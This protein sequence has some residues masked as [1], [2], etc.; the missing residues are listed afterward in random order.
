[1]KKS[2]FAVAFLCLFFND[3]SA[4]FL[5]V[6]FKGGVNFSNFGDGTIEGVAFKNISSYHF[7][8]ITELKLLEN[9]AIQP[10]LLY[11]SQG[12][13]LKGLGEEFTNELGY[14]TLPILIKFYVVSNKLSIEAGPQAAVLIS[15]KNV[16]NFEDAKTF[17]LGFASGLSYKITKNIFVSGRYIAGL[18]DAKKDREI[19]N[20]VIQLSVGF[21]F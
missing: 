2:F 9:F 14:I 19:K 3:T 4:Q 12:A 16:V 1:M 21:L 18:T 20:S 17:E 11:S 13:E 6:G 7:G 5:Q 8:L 10:E 15:E